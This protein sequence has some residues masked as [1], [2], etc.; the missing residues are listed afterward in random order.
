MRIVAIQAVIFL[1]R[2]ASQIPISVESTMDAVFVV[3]HL[4]AMAL[5]A[6]SHDVGE[7]DTT[8]I[9]QLQ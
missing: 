3:F 6:E 9:G 2:A 8:T 1:L 4:R 7:I 5:T